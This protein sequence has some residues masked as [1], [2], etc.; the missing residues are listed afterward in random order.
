MALSPQV[1]IRDY[2]NVGDAVDGLGDY[3]DFYNHRRLHQSLQYRNRTPAAV[4][5]Q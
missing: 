4:Y 2:Q 3:F 5:W 1:Y